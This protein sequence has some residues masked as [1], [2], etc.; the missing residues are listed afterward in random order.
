MFER[1]GFR[2]DRSDAGDFEPS[3]EDRRRRGGDFAGRL[4][5][6]FRESY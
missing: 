1:D 5:I 6:I 4:C 3:L 2:D